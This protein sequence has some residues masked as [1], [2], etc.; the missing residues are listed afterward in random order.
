MYS[1]LM[2]LLLLAVSLGIPAAF[3]SENA[4]GDLEKARAFIQFLV[5]HKGQNLSTQTLDDYLNSNDVG[6]SSLNLF[7]RNTSII[8]GD[9]ANNLDS[10]MHAAVAI[11]SPTLVDT[12]VARGGKLTEELTRKREDSNG[13]TFSQ[14]AAYSPACAVLQ[15]CNLDMMSYLLTKGADFSKIECSQDYRDMSN[16]VELSGTQTLMNQIRSLT[17]LSDEDRSSEVKSLLDRCS[18]VALLL[19]INDLVYQ[20]TSL[21]SEKTRIRLLEEKAQKQEKE[22]TELK[23]MLQKLQISR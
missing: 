12:L 3:S 4:P 14:H 22:L 7:S 20:D 23:E 5:A 16:I 19:K 8:G 15:V 9:E 2:I 1:R 17:N 10:P 13:G 21:L 11:L 6:P 18:K